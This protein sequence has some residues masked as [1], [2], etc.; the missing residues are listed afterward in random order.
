[1]S[2]RKCLLALS[3]SLLAIATPR[4]VFCTIWEQVER[5]L[6]QSNSLLGHDQVLEHISLLAAPENIIE[7]GESVVIAGGYIVVGPDSIKSFK[8]PGDEASEFEFFFNKDF[9]ATDIPPRQDLNGIRIALDA[10]P[11]CSY[12]DEILIGSYSYPKFVAELQTTLAT[13]LAEAGG[14]ISLLR[15]KNN[16]NADAL[17]E[18]PPHLVIS[19]QFNADQ[20]NAMLT[21][22]GGNILAPEL[23]HEK[24]RARFIQA[25]LT[26]KHISS[27]ALGA[28]ITGHCQEKLKV[29]ALSWPKASFEGNVRPLSCSVRIDDVNQLV[30]HKGNYNGIGTRNLVHN[31]IFAQAVVVPFPDMKWVKEQV[32]EGE[33][34]EWIK[35]YAATLSEAVV[36]Y[37]KRHSADFYR[38]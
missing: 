2:I 11:S 26:G 34:S 14:E 37:V 22:C 12:F 16:I 27:A 6:A 5:S 4:L 3:F 35:T 15:P 7:K 23:R 19:P 17:N 24:M 36:D 10:V 1:M 29:E 9:I 20:Q 21:F 30:Q 13:F 18:N 8:N 28:C 38:H 31:G 32:V 33:E 25:A